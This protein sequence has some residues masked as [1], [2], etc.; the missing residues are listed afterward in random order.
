MARAN[1]LDRKTLRQDP[2]VTFT[3]RV[4]D[5]VDRNRNLIL[6]GVVAA[7]AA[8]VLLVFWSK[9]RV[10][11]SAESDL[12]MSAVFS[13]L[14]LG[15][16]QGALDQAEA[17][18]ASYGGTRAAAVATFLAGQAQ[19]RLGNYVAAEQAF[20][21]FAPLQDQAPYYVGAAAM[22]LGASLEGQQ[23]FGEAARQ[24]QRAIDLVDAPIADQARIDAARCHRAAG[25][26][27]QA[28]ELLEE[29]KNSESSYSRRAA[30]ELAVLDGIEGAAVGS[31]P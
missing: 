11:R 10:D 21:A 24:F 26:F 5:F 13:G 16:Y 27:A 17:I 3:G 29:V 15:D 28:R 4:A 30:I 2:L 19:L 6:G 22:G 1:R 12:R 14:Q 31:N 9:G 18:R 8:V 25:E 23:R 7:V 20:N